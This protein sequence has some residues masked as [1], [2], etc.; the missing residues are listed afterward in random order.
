MARLPTR[1]NRP[2]VS[3]PTAQATPAAPAEQPTPAQPAPTE[4]QPPKDVES[5]APT[6]TQPDPLAPRRTESTDLLLCLLL[7]SPM[8]AFH[9]GDRRLLWPIVLAEFAALCLWVN[10]TDA[11]IKV[12]TLQKVKESW[13]SFVKDPLS[14][15][16][17]IVTN[18]GGKLTS[19][20]YQVVAAIVVHVLVIAAAV[21]MYVKRSDSET[22]KKAAL[23]PRPVHPTDYVMLVMDDASLGAYH[24]PNRTG[25]MIKSVLRTLFVFAYLPQCFLSMLGLSRSEVSMYNWALLVI[26]VG[27]SAVNLYRFQQL[28]GMT[29]TF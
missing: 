6:P 19:R 9:S 26:H 18:L 11:Q 4:T 27:T 14:K 15:A 10:G 8:F 17:T 12:T 16:W 25:L 2:S 28:A 20:E 13:S 21:F 23:L 1:P 7:P 24:S 29:N 5:Q 22:Q 3:E